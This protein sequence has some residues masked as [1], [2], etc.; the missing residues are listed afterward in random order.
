MATF[1]IK[2]AAIMRNWP[3][4]DDSVVVDNNLYDT[5]E[6]VLNDWEEGDD[7]VAVATV[8]WEQ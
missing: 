5:R 2:Y 4:T 3:D 6:E 8:V 1:N 7:F